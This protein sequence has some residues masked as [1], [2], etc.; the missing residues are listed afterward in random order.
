MFRVPKDYHPKHSLTS[1]AVTTESAAVDLEKD[2]SLAQKLDY[3]VWLPYAAKTYQISS[4]IESYV[5]IPTP[6]CPSGVPNRNGIGFPLQELLR[7]MAPPVGRQVFKA[8]TGCPLHLEHDNEDCTKAF[9][10]VLDTMFM[11]IKG[12]GNGKFWKVMG[13]AAVDKEKHPDIAQSMLDNKFK[14]FSMGCDAELLKC[15]ICGTQVHGK[16]KAHL[17]CRHVTSADDVNFR[18]YNDQ[19]VKKLAYITA[20]YLTPKELSIVA[21]PAWAPALSDT[22][23]TA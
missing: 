21:D 18:V 1:A 22:V 16:K 2:P 9:G 11:P 12:Y 3:E 23:L 20:H 8:W 14:T 15:S 5:V 4:H 7:Y 13:L 6:I 10:V 19:G 17:N